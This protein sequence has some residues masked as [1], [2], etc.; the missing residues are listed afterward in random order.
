MH[1]SYAG[2]VPAL[3][4]AEPEWESPG[5]RRDLL[6]QPLQSVHSTPAVPDAL[7]AR[8]PPRIGNGNGGQE[9]DIWNIDECPKGPQCKDPACDNFHHVVER[10]CRKFVLLGKNGCRSRDGRCA[11]GLHVKAADVCQ[12]YKLNLETSEAHLLEASQ[13]LE[14]KSPDDRATYIRIVVWNFAAVRMRALK[15]FLE[16][17]PLVHELFL[18]DRDFCPFHLLA[19]IEFVN[20]HLYQSCPKLRWIVFGDGTAET[21][22]NV[23]APNN[24]AMTL[25]DPLQVYDPWSSVQ[26]CLAGGTDKRSCWNTRKLDWQS[27]W[28]CQRC[29]TD[30]FGSRSECRNCRERSSPPATGQ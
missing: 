3:D 15:C 17:L 12:I 19:M 23:G 2:K 10:R 7:Q 8:Q 18:P 27:N 21:V 29:G 9:S 24:Q 26:S 20:R 6:R 11:S 22:H 13:Q 25:V 4:D 30:N 28:C 14:A 16:K 5:Y 1:A